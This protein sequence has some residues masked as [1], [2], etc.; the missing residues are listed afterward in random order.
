MIDFRRVLSYNDVLLVPRYSGLDHVTDADIYYN[1]NNIKWG[2][3]GLPL[4][5]APMDTVCSTALLKLLHDKFLM[6]VTIH[7]WFKSVEDQIKFYNECNFSLEDY[8][9]FIAIGNLCKWEGWIER[10]LS[11][12]RSNEKK[13]SVLI[14]VANGDTK[15]TIETVKYIKS[16]YDVNVMAGNIAT[17]SA[18][19]RLQESGADFIRTGIGGG[20]FTP[21]MNVRTDKG[22]KSIS[23]IQNGDMVY[24]HKGVLQEVISTLSY[25]S[26]EDIIEINDSIKCTKN[27][28]FYVLNKKYMNIVSSENINELAQWISAD[29]LNDDYCLIELDE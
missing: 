12:R 23:S 13:F 8:D 26:D 22:L 9:V 17:R 18:F 10:L 20:C 25:E 2:F 3:H 27:H 4:I 1:Y 29:E 6:P 5:N 24:S 19:V 16:H 14:D 21:D 28:E 7:R 15:A 11:Y